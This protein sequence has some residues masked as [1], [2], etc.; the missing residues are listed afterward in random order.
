MLELS[1]PKCIRWLP[2]LEMWDWNFMQKAVSESDS[3]VHP[4]DNFLASQSAPLVSRFF[5]HTYFDS[6]L[7]GT[8]DVSDYVSFLY[9]TSWAIVPFEG[10]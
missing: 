4:S 8:G 1:L 2:F 5:I 3:A 7:C 6:L 10:Q 9:L